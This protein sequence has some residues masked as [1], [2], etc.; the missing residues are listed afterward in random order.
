M[1]VY[2][3]Y[4]DDPDVVLVDLRAGTKEVVKSLV[5]DAS[6]TLA[7]D[8]SALVFTSSRRGG[9]DDLWTQPLSEGKLAGAPRPLTDLAGGV[10]TPAY[11]PDGKWV[12]FKR[13]LSGRREIWVVPAAGGMPERL[14]DGLGR[15]LHP[16]WSPDGSQIAFVSERGP[17][18]HIWTAPISEGR[19]TGPSRQLTDGPTT[20]RLPAWSGD[21]R[22]IAYARGSEDHWE[23][24]IVPASGGSPSGPIAKETLIGR[25]RWEKA[26]GWLWFGAVV[27]LG[28]TEIRKVSPDGGAP[29]A[30]LSGELF[31]EA[32]PPGDFDLSSDGRL[33]AFTRQQ[34]RGD[35]W[36]V[37]NRRGSY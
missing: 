12:A 19:R 35:I 2:S 9:Q 4:V 8:G 37:E 11:S 29:V 17:E 28:E 24:W 6:P 26:S 20:D 27:G 18:S 23:I 1:F 36:L 14:S 15:D 33:L 34:L 32:A 31:A 16:A 3:T 22:K 10:N 30:A 5:Y 13:E 7:P 25:L 21:G